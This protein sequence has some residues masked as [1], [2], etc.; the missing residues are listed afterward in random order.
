MIVI[1]DIRGSFFITN[2]INNL[3]RLRMISGMP[4]NDL[5]QWKHVIYDGTPDNVFGT[6][7]NDPDS[8]NIWPKLNVTC[9]CVLYHDGVSSP[10]CSGTPGGKFYTRT[11]SRRYVFSGV[12]STASSSTKKTYSPHNHI[13]VPVHHAFAGVGL[14]P[15]SI[16][17]ID[18][19]FSHGRWTGILE[20]DNS[21]AF[22]LLFTFIYIRVGCLDWNNSITFVFMDMIIVLMSHFA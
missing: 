2:K 17:T 11:D 3:V 16:R 15:I 14:G 5:L 13:Y 21:V 12:P 20:Q 8:K 9:P 10:I 22:H 7:F 18:V 19:A 4:F 1:K 6:L